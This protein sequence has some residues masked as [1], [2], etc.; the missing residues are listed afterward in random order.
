MTTPASS[1]LACMRPA[2]WIQSSSAPSWLLWLK[3]REKPWRAQAAAHSCCTSASVCMP[4]T[5]GSRWPSRFR[6]GPLRTKTVFMDMLSGAMRLPPYRHTYLRRKPQAQ[7]E[8]PTAAAGVSAVA[9]TA[10]FFCCA[11]R[12]CTSDLWVMSPTSYQTVRWGGKGV[13]WSGFLLLFSVCRIIFF[14]SHA[15]TIDQFDQGHGGVVTH[16]E[17]HL[18]DP[19]VAT[20]TQPKVG[21]QNVE[22][23]GHAG[24]LAQAVEGQAAVGH[25]VL[26]GQRDHGFD[27]APQFLGLGERGLDDFVLDER[28]HHVLQHRKAVRTGAVEFAKAVSVAHG[29]FLLLHRS[30]GRI[31]YCPRPWFELN[32]C[33][34]QRVASFRASCPA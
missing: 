16:A 20:G 12:I 3:G 18:Q 23:L 5:A 15:G 11:R 10:T 24:P 14:G 27:H 22:Q 29:A 34:G 2:S 7:T 6:L 26:L 28:I 1:P 8:T 31:R 32:V 30:G 9:A 25:R 4:Y 17:T 33:P 19:G 13:L 21:A